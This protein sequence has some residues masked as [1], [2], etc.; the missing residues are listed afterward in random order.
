MYR[1]D[2]TIVWKIMISAPGISHDRFSCHRGTAE[3]APRLAC[4]RVT[5]TVALYLFAFYR[6]PC[7]GGGVDGEFV[8]LY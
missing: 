5:E 3:D 1:P 6:V 8:S 2:K 4:L 7:S